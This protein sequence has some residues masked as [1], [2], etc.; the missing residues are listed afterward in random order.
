MLLGLD[1]GTSAVKALLL[2]RRG[3][4]V[5]ESSAPCAVERP[6]P[7][8][9]ESDPGR[10]WEAVVAAVRRLPREGRGAVA[11]VGLSGQMHGVVL[12]GTDGAPVRPAILWL[13]GRS[14]ETLER[15]PEGA[16]RITGNAPSAGMTGP[17]LLW[18]AAH[19]PGA[20]RAAR[21]ALLAKDW[22][23]LRLTGE[24]A[25]DPSDASGTL[26]ADRDGRW[27]EPLVAAL[28]IRR[29]LLPPVVASERTSGELARAAADELGLP[30]GV[31]VA[32]GAGDTLAAALGSGLLADGAAQLAIG[33]SA[34]VARVQ[35]T[36]P[37][38]SPR[39]NVYRSANPEGLPRWCRLAAMLNGG[40]ALE[41]ARGV[42]GL[43]WEE[44]HL[45]AFAPGA[46]R[47]T[48]TF[49][50]YLA[51]ERTP[52]MDAQVRGAW[53]GLSPR[54]DPGSL[55][56]AAF[57]GVALGIRAGLDALREEGS[58]IERLRLAGGGTVHPAWRQLLA[59]TLGVPLDAVSCPGAA[60]RGAA[61][62]G[63]LAAGLYS[64]AE[65]PALAPA[66]APAA[67][68]RGGPDPERQAR[69]RALYA[70]L[71]GWPEAVGT[72]GAPAARPE[73]VEGQ[74]DSSVRGSTGSPGADRAAGRGEGDAP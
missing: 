12:A 8:I 26:L 41:W 30:A 66:A 53:V 9:A 46:A 14:A 65:L 10:W 39:L 18:L 31:P 47:S 58:T 57:E 45:R 42:L 4:P 19:E 17:A 7:G 64:A 52:W 62:L 68:P 33:S 2:D 32:G 49:L 72:G 34:Q 25:T 61:L 51:G 28:G 35:G 20:V 21:W 16:A 37:G 36:W 59:D 38:F 44:A 22:L 74:V 3:E 24:A 15:Y 29:E 63:G 71:A 48:A 67:A 6:G 69:F 5:G 55:M 50:P 73:P 1:L 70:R 60:A 23:R 40:L 54:D 13:D 56:R 11:G 27:D 43:S